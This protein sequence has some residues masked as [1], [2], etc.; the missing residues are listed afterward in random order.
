MKSLSEEAVVTYL[1]YCYGSRVEELENTAKIL[2][3][4]SAEKFIEDLSNRILER[5]D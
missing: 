5:Y 4:I 1:I 2:A 3:T